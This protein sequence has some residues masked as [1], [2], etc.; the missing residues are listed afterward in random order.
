MV[1][2]EFDFDQIK[3]TIQANLEDKFQEAINRYSQKSQ[4]NIDSICFFAN[5]QKINPEKTVESQMSQLNK[6]DNKMKVLVNLIND[7]KEDQI[8]VGSKDIICPK[9][10]EPCQFNIEKYKIKLYD[11][12]NGH[13]SNNIKIKDFQNTQKINISN[14]KCSNCK[15]NNKGNSYNQ[16][17]YKC[18]TCGNNLCPLCKTNH[19]SKH[20]IINYDQKNYLCQRHNDIFTKYCIN[21]KSNLCFSCENEHSDHS[22][23]YYGDLMP[24]INKIKEQ[25]L[26]KK[27]V[28]DLF[29]E[30]I[31][32]IIR[33]LNDL[34]ETLD[35]YYKID[36][37]ILNNY[38]TRN[39]NYSIFENL[40]Y[41]SINNEIYENL[42]EINK[43][44]NIYNQLLNLI[45]LNNKLNF[46]YDLSKNNE[47]INNEL[48][49][50]EKS[51]NSV[52]IPKLVNI[53]KKENIIDDNSH[54]ELF[55]KMQIIYNIEKNTEKIRLFGDNFVKNNKNNCYLLIDGK[56]K[57]LCTEFI[58]NPN[59]KQNDYLEIKLTEIQKITN[60]SCMFN[61]CRLYKIPEISN[62]VSKYVTDISGM[63]YQCESLISLPDISKW[64]TRNVINMSYLFYECKSLK[65]LPDI[66]KWDTGNVNDISFL[67]YE[68]KSL[69]S[70][71]DISKWNT[72]N[73][74]N[75]SSMLSN[76]ILLK[77]L[78]DI[79]KWNTD[80]VNN[81][82]YML[83]G[84]NSLVSLPD[85]SKWN[86]KNL[87]DMKLMFYKC[88]SLEFLPDITK[89]DIQEDLDMTDIFKE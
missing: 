35:A 2:I 50:K 16:E 80:N 3:T 73:I 85:I 51:N 89:W 14:I 54:V 8:I 64:D 9:C 84:C 74:I 71:P 43:Q 60:M 7:E 31:K 25:L 47:K 20:S 49:I 4:I 29:K 65:T 59:Q 13:I 21:C 82:S 52:V 79:S 88:E 70:L 61:Q 42:E 11:C 27:N 68:C 30:K 44:D 55:N 48:T 33:L 26:M 36:N 45:D 75:M 22:T 12:T 10:H 83:Y 57:E 19:D 69:V 53:I 78:P 1:Q 5:G 72:K 18:L 38:D 23:L 63:F 87:K 86:T 76:C 40:K 67:F 81:I 17:F 28:I 24:N 32:G 37:G 39:R 77:S 66:S 62:L 56:Q 6:D 34:A 58:L 46:D 15:N 41:L